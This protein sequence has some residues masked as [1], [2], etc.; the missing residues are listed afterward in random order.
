MDEYDCGI[1]RSH[2]LATIQDLMRNMFLAIL[3]SLLLEGFPFQGKL[4][5]Y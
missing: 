5:G 2:G 1:C 4:E 3:G